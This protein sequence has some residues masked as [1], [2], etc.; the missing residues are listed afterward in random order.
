[1][2]FEIVYFYVVILK[3]HKILFLLDKKLKMKVIITTS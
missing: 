3:F 1:M 2:A